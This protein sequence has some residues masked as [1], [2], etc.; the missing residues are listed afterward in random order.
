ML[1][2]RVILLL[3]LL[4]AELRAQDRWDPSPPD[5][6]AL[7]STVPFAADLLSFDQWLQWILLPRLQAL[8]DLG[9]ALPARCAIRPMAEEVYSD[10]DLAAQRIV[11]LLGELD[12]VLNDQKDD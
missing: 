7:Q 4:E 2:D 1:H 6:A 5:A 11:G 12:R 10:D 3:S 9:A 8:L